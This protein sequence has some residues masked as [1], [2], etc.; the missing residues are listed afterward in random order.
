[1]TGGAIIFAITLELTLAV[2]CRRPLD[3]MNIVLGLACFLA[4]YAFFAATVPA[5]PARA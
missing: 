1:V 2:T 3:A 5:D 4:G